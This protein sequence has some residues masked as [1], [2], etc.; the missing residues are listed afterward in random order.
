MQISTTPTA[1]LQFM[2]NR[3]DHNQTPQAAQADAPDRAARQA[4]V[5]QLAQ[6]AKT[7][8]ES[9]QLGDKNELT[10]ALDRETGHPVM[11]I[12]DR[13]SREVLQQIPSERV[14]RMAEEFKRA[15]G[16]LNR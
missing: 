11:R 14:L 10:I 5:R 8:N 1:T 3:T 2:T 7:I 9:G 15:A 13:T 6:A 16:E 12:I 4:E